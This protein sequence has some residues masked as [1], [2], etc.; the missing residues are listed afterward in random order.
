MQ[1]MNTGEC[2]YRHE[3]NTGEHSNTLGV[4]WEWVFIAIHL[5]EARRLI[6][7]RRLIE[8]GVHTRRRSTVVI[9]DN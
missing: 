1:L 9:L 4:Y 8:I 3:T 5:I 2:Q 6:K 7:A